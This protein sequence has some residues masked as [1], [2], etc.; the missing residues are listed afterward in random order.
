MQHV[1]FLLQGITAKGQQ[2]IKEWGKD[3]IVAEISDTVQFSSEP[4]P[5]FFIIPSDIPTNNSRGAYS[6]S[7]WIHSKRDKDFKILMN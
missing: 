6:G 3:W 2:R 7:R 4:G 1:T 5:W